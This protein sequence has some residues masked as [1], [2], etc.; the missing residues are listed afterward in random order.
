M[1]LRLK[2]I[3]IMGVHWKIWFLREA[4]HENQ[5]TGG[6]CLKRGAWSVCRFKKGGVGGR[7]GGALGEKEGRV[8]LKGAEVDTV[9]HSVGCICKGYAEVRICTIWICLNMP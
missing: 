5:Y 4:L 1:G 2:N 8:F 6:G 3:D 9:M 7:R